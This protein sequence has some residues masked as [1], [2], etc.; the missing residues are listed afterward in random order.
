[1]RGVRKRKDRA[2][3]PCPTTSHC[4]WSSGRSICEDMGALQCLGWLSGWACQVRSHHDRIGIVG[5]AVS[6][7]VRQ[8]VSVKHSHLDESTV[9]GGV[10]VDISRNACSGELL[11]ESTSELL[12]LSVRVRNLDEAKEVG[13]T[14]D[15]GELVRIDL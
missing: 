12:G 11:D 2:G 9:E 10:H 15:C 4:G 13:T 3:H 14:G 8:L 1:M 5:D 6:E 7:G